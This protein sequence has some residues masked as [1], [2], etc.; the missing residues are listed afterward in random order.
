MKTPRRRLLNLLLAWTCAAVG[1]LIVCDGA[2][3][4]VLQGSVETS[5]VTPG[6]QKTAA[7]PSHGIVGLD[8]VIRP[9]SFPLVHDVFANTP[10]WQ[11]GI[12]PG[13]QLLAVNG[14]SVYG[15]SSWEVD[16][17]ISDVPGEWVSLTVQRQSA[18]R[19]VRLRVASLQTMP[20]IIRAQFLTS[21]F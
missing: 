14:E 13:D 4:K 9:A 16:Q 21:L 15:R 5:I 17:R 7:Q 1:A 19:N 6:E 20:A 3:A 2:G 10:A 11:A 12:R 8:M 18:V